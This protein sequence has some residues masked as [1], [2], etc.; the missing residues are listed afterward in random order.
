MRITKNKEVEIVLKYLSNENLLRGA[1]KNSDVAVIE[2]TQEIFSKVYLDLKDE[3]EIKRVEEQEREKKRLE[4]IAQIEAQGFKLNE[5]I[6]SKKAPS[7]K[8]NKYVFLDNEGNVLY[9]SG[10]GKMPRLLKEQVERGEPL[11]S[12]LIENQ[13]NIAESV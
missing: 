2:H 5:L 10:M 11:E 13:Q 8:P 4:L 6:K 3:L 9:W 1:F 12:F 7:K